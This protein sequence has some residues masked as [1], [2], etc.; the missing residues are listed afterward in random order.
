MGIRITIDGKLLAEA[1]AQ[2]AAFG[3]T[4]GAIVEDALRAA[5]ARSATVDRRGVGARSSHP[6]LPVFRGSR[7]VAGVDL[8]SSAALL[9]RM[10]RAEP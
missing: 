4:L 9:E 10:E 1:R 7:L 3:L 6:P 5:L 8:D 2:A